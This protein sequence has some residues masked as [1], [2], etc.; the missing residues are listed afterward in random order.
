Y[1]NFGE[2]S[3]K[4]IKD[5]LTAKGLSLGAPAEMEESDIFGGGGGLVSQGAVKD[6]GVLGT[7]LALIDLSIRARKALE[8][9]RLQTLGDLV[10]KSEA[11]LLAC[12]NFGQTSLHEIRQRLSEYGLRLHEPD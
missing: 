2:T 7:R 4:E 8:V 6:E 1:K 9:L 5:M 12:K 11:E 3:L 10:A